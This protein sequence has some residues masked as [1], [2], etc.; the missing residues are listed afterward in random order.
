[1][2]IVSPYQFQ[3]ARNIAFR[4]LYR[5]SRAGHEGHRAKVGQSV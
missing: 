1:M 3:N 2:M 4:P 5:I